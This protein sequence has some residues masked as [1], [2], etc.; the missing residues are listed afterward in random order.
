MW[1]ADWGLRI[2]LQSA[3]RIARS[4]KRKIL[5]TLCSLLYA[6]CLLIPEANSVFHFRFRVFGYGTIETDQVGVQFLPLA[7]LKV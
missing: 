3:E 6:L 2:K 7:T 5:I 1:N 4:V